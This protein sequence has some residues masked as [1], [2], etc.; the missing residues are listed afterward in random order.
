MGDPADI[1][2]RIQNL[3]RRVARRDAYG[4]L[5]ATGQV[6]VKLADLD[7][8]EQWRADLRRQARADRIKIRTGVTGK[9]AYALLAA[10]L[11]SIR[12]DEN[13]R[14]TVAMQAAIPRAANLR[15]EP[16]VLL[17]D[18]D[19]TVCGCERCPALG[20]VVAEADFSIGG[21]L[22]EEECSVEGPARSTSV[23]FSFGGAGRASPAIDLDAADPEADR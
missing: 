20:L 10:E 22:F 9:I 7:D 15:H 8:P 13:D 4:T 21:G 1:R 12:R 17:R 6:I 23:T 18:G 2:D 16:K 3:A 14:Y 5:L 19:E 11:T